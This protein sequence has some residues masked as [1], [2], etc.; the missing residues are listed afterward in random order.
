MKRLTDK[1][2]IMEKEEK[3]IETTFGR[4]APFKVPEGYFDDFASRMMEQIPVTYNS[5]A[6]VYELKPSMW[7]RYRK[8]IGVAAACIAVA[9]IGTETY[10]HHNHNNTPEEQLAST[11]T[12]STYSTMDALTDYAML[13]SDDMYAY[14]ADIK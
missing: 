2:D 6:V 10:M 13:D 7:K 9:V 1:R 12:Q 8:V 3:Y 14:M 11:P 5:T 4:K